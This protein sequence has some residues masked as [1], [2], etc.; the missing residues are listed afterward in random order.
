MKRGRPLRVERRRAGVSIGLGQL[1]S[2]STPARA[3]PQ[4]QAFTA[5]FM[6][7]EV[8]MLFAREKNKK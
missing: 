7:P 5:N 4:L 3:L 6:A 2:W 8:S 1:P